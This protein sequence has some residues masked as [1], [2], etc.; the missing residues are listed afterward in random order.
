MTVLLKDVPPNTLFVINNGIST[1][2]KIFR[3]AGFVFDRFDY[4]GESINVYLMT[5]FFNGTRR[6][7]DLSQHAGTVYDCT[8]IEGSPMNGFSDLPATYHISMDYNS[9]NLTR[10]VLLVVGPAIGN[11]MFRK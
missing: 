7:F 1:A 5:E 11:L 3:H 6:N 10:S 4:D 9:A 8:I 2:G